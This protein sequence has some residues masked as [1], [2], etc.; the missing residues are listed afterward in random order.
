[1][2]MSLLTKLKSGEKRDEVNLNLRKQ[3]FSVDEKMEKFY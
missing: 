1:M 2:Q 3:L